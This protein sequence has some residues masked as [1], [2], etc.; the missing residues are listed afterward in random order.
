MECSNWRGMCST[1]LLWDSVIGCRQNIRGQAPARWHL[2]GKTTLRLTPLFCLDP[3]PALLLR[4]L[5]SSFSLPALSSIF[6]LLNGRYTLL[7]FCFSLWR[8]CIDVNSLIFVLFF[9]PTQA[10]LRKIACSDISAKLSYKP[11]TFWANFKVKCWVSS[12]KIAF[13]SFWS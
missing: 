1:P 13:S 9:L 8:N 11:C 5:H 10:H 4:C 7:Y 2:F 12:T 6:F 3:S